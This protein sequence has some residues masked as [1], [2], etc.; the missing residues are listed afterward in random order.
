[1]FLELVQRIYIN[2]E[3]LSMKNAL[4]VAVLLAA[5]LTACGKNEAPAAA[6]PAVAP[7]PVVAP[8]PAGVSPTSAAPAANAADRAAAS[9]PLGTAN[10]VENPACSTC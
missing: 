9:N 4:L 6:A 3:T 2:N 10:K 5:T 8:A 7:A 1:M